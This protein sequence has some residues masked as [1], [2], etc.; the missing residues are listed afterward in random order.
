MTLARRTHSRISAEDRAAIR[1]E[2]LREVRTAL[3]S[4]TDFEEFRDAMEESDPSLP[5]LTIDEIRAFTP[6]QVAEHQAAVDAVLEGTARTG[7]QLRSEGNPG[8][9]PLSMESLK[10]MS[11]S[12]YEARAAEIDAF[13]ARGGRAA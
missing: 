4:A 13:L 5:G 3:D 2:V 11:V 9:A 7:Q 6:A 8:P 10:P 12:E 1:N